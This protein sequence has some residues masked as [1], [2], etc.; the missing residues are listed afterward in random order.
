MPRKLIPLAVLATALV[1]TGIAVAHDEP[2]KVSKAAASFD[3]K[4]PGKVTIREC[5]G[6]DGHTLRVSHGVWQ[7]TLDLDAPANATVRASFRGK[8][9]VDTT[10]G[11]GWAT[12]VVRF[13]SDLVRPRGYGG[14]TAV[15]S[16][17]SKLDGV[18]A[19]RM[20]GTGRLVANVTATLDAAG[21]KGAL[22][23]GTGTNSAVVISGSC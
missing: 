5:K 7:G 17:G 3:L 14:L 4:A 22:G 9:A 2:A 10:T 12:G 13:G 19:G 23:T 8:V 1:A 20:R 15:V 21:L 11:D 16:G 6:A 18:L